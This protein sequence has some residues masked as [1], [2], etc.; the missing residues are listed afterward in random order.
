MMNSS[1]T[2]NY[3]HKHGAGFCWFFLPNMS[4]VLKTSISFIFTFITHSRS[5]QLLQHTEFFSPSSL[6]VHFP[7]AQ[8]TLPQLSAWLL[9]HPSRLHFE[10]YVLREFFPACLIS[11]KFSFLTFFSYLSEYLSPFITQ[12]SLNLLHVINELIFVKCLEQCKAHKYYVSDDL[13]KKKKNSHNP[14]NP[15]CAINVTFLQRTNRN[16]E[17]KQ[18]VQSCTANK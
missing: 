5:F 6:W 18:L 15:T 1:F 17:V 2:F 7:C 16:R 11:G 10:K 12:N 3:L 4:C 8:N 14:H 13:K 9:L